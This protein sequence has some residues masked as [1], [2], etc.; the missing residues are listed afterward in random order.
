MEIYHPQD[1]EL[2][3]EMRRVRRVAKQ[4][5]L[6]WG[7]LISLVL[8]AAFG[9][10]VFSR[11]F[12]LAVC[13][14][15]G[16]GTALPGGSLVLIRRGEGLE[17]RQGDIV[18]IDGE[19]G[20]QLKRVIAVGGDRVVVNPYGEIR[21]NST[22]IRSERFSGRTEDTGV[23]ARRLTVPERELFVQGD[24][25]SLSVDSRWR[26]YGTVRQEDV[27][28]KASFILWPLYRIGAPASVLEE[29]PEA[30]PA[31]GGAGE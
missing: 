15:P 1:D 5:R 7:L 10:L 30:A 4:K 21:V 20:R 31:E 8:S 6:L 27:A 22:E 13:E 17:I 9:W 25:L 19:D 3:R 18:L 26:D 24:Q 2:L 12:S 23:T 29:A 11:Y 28:G 16:M 14:G